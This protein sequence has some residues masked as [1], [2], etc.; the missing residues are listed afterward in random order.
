[1]SLAAKESVDRLMA[2]QHGVATRG[3]VLDAGGTA[4]L[5]DHRLEVGAWEALAS[6]IYAARS[7]PVTWERD[8]SAALLSR[9]GSMACRRSAAILHGLDGFRTRRPEIVIPYG[10]N[11]RSPIAT[12]R[13]SVYFDQLGRTTIG[14][15]PVT[16]VAETLFMLAGVVDLGRLGRLLDDALAQ[17]RCS[18][19]DLND[20]HLRHLGDRIPGIGRFQVALAV[21]QTDAKARPESE[22]ERHLHR[23]LDDPDLPAVHFQHTA[24]WIE[25]AHRVDAFIPSW[26]L[27]IEADGRTWHTRVA[28]F[29]RDRARDNAAAA[30]GH[31]VLRF[32]WS[33]LTKR[34]DACRRQIMSVGAQRASLSNEQGY[35]PLV[36]Q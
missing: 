20:V 32:T 29:E 10:G 33:M 3:Q 25:G 28:D 2:I 7:A 35:V 16:N 23:L 14:G 4:S 34:A 9:P 13:R 12:I 6:G 15:F 30:A 19:D 24:P 18:I 8:L 36:A 26:S 11:A 27:V 22:L 31:A 17:A 5:I 1:M 21:R